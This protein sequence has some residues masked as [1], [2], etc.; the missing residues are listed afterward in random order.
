[1]EQMPGMEEHLGGGGKQIY[2]SSRLHG[3]QSEF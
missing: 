2:V 3:L 1:M